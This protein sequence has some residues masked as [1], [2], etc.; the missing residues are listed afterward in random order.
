MSAGA[1]CVS[2]GVL[3]GETTGSGAAEGSSDGSGSMVGTGVAGMPR[4]P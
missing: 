1:V 2:T 4:G 3:S